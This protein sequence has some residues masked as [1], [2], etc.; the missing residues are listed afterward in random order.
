MKLTLD[1]LKLCTG[2]ELRSKHCFQVTNQRSFVFVY[3]KAF[4]FYFYFGWLWTGNDDHLQQHIIL[5]SWWRPKRS[6]RKSCIWHN[7]CCKVAWYVITSVNKVHCCF[8]FISCI[9]FIFC[10]V[11]CP[12][13][14]VWNIY[15]W[16]GLQ[17][18]THTKGKLSLWSMEPELKKPKTNRTSTPNSVGW[19]D[20]LRT[21][22]TPAFLLLSRVRCED[23]E[24]AWGGAEK[25]KPSLWFLLSSR[26]AL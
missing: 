6:Y 14:I 10:R 19:T 22:E 1:G 13:V 15:K 26:W 7:I 16:S 18:R 11:F 4:G 24:E 8:R 2:N 20:A 21:S 23:W 5:S 12:H 9:H 25:V 3:K 17:Q